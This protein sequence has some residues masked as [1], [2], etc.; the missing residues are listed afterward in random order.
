MSDYLARVRDTSNTFR[1]KYEE[2]LQAGWSR[3]DAVVAA[4]DAGHLIEDIAT[5]ANVSRQTISKILR[6]ARKHTQK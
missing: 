4:R 1:G 5:A 6:D 3:D 2:Y